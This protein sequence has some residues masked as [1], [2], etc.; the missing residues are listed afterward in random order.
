MIFSLIEDF[1][2]EMVIDMLGDF[3]DLYVVIFWVSVLV[4]EAERYFGALVS[5]CWK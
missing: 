5:R 2:K 1:R 4:E 3:V